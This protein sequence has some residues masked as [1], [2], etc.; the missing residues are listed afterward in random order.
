MN[1]SDPDKP[2][3]EGPSRPPLLAPF[4]VAGACGILGLW[5]LFARPGFWG[6][7]IGGL[8]LGC[9]LGGVVGAVL[10]FMLP[11][12]LLVLLGA[13]PVVNLS[14]LLPTK[15][16]RARWREMRH[17][18]LLSD[19]EFYERFYADTGVGREIPL[20]LRQ[21]YATQLA[22]DR[23][24]PAEKATE[25]D[26]ELDFADLLAEVEEEFNVEVSDHEALRLDGSF[27][28]IA[29]LVASKLDS[30]PPESR[31]E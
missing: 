11:V 3:R 19:N 12:C 8:P 27:D 25:F 10:V 29:R 22:M 9:L 21:I 20:R 26:S 16:E 13:R 28:S 1:E 24:W 31:K 2:Q 30:G 14:L 6:F 15:E 23:V 4:L 7:T 17:R 5:L 18:P